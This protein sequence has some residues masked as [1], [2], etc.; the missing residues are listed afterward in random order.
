MGFIV[1]CIMTWF[2]G[3]MAWGAYKSPAERQKLFDEIKEAP[4]QSTFMIAW[5][6]SIY[7]FVI[8]IFAPIF[9]EN[10]FFNTG[11]QIWQVGGLVALAGWIVTW[12]WKIE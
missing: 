8:G 6:T 7:V 5:L 10:E 4:A 2:I 1:F 11:W 3:V 12:F 9:G